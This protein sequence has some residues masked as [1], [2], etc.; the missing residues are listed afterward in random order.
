[1][2]GLPRSA[3]GSLGGAP[4]ERPVGPASPPSRKDDRVV[5]VK[6]KTRAFPKNWV[7]SFSRR[8]PEL[9]LRTK[10]LVAVGEDDYV[11]EFEIHGGSTDWTEE[12]AASADV[13]EVDRIEASDDHARYRVRYHH[14]PMFR[15]ASTFQVLLR[16]PTVI[17][18]GS[19]T[20]Q[21]IAWRSQLRELVGA[22]QEAGA[23]PRI[24]ALGPDE[25]TSPPQATVVMLT[26]VQRTLFRQALA[27]G[28]FEVPRR[29]TLT[30]LAERVSRSK[31]SVSR[32]LAVVERKL[33]ENASWAET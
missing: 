4:S 29:I 22:L 26:P 6:M 24:V 7:S 27:T 14:A 19:V 28:Y 21:M 2:T 33:A 31:S 15:I 3:S 23:D 9:E 10:N 13:M 12:I 16:L 18:N 11:G 5:I 17:R 25:P 8:H 1:M 32:T 30:Q 20:V